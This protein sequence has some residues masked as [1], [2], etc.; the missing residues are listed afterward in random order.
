[1]KKVYM[2][3]LLEEVEIRMEGM[4]ALST[5]VDGEATDPAMAPLEEIV[6]VA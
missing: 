4:L 2:Q 5:D 3:P 6:D 1:M